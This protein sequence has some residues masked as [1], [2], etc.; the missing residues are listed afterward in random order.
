MT[1]GDPNDIHEELGVRFQRIP[2]PADEAEIRARHESNRLGWNEGA[3]GYRARLEETIASL[4]AGRSNLH[5]LE[6]ANLAP[7]GPLRSWCRVA[8]HLQCA[9][10]ED[11][12][13]LWLEGA[14]RVVGVDISD[15]HIENAR[16]LSEALD[17][18]ATWI[19]SDVLDAPH[20]WDGTADLVYTGRG[21]LCWIHDIRGWASVVARLLRPGGVVHVLDDHPATILFDPDTERPVATGRAYF[22]YSEWSQGWPASYLGNMGRPVEEHARKYERVWPLA[23]VVQAL[24]DAGLRLERIGEH[25]DRYWNNFERLTASARASLPLT[26]TLLARRPASSEGGAPP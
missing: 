24:L 26:F 23:S 19:R 3:E 4:R 16:A 2:L 12:L 14:E 7:L 13:S 11:T 1:P 17:A 9:S 15:R 5:P 18:P 21:A 25:P 8:I 10:G 6:R 22:G 20:E